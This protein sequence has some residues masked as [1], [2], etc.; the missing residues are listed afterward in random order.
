MLTNSSFL[1]F[2][3]FVFGVHE[4]LFFFEC[5]SVLFFGCV[6]IL[7]CRSLSQ[8]TMLTKEFLVTDTQ[9]LHV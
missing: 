3:Y 1:R 8:D 7:L 9:F 5:M 4:C 6:M 2:L